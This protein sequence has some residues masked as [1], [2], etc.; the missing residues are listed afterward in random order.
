MDNLYPHYEHALNSSEDVSPIVEI[1]SSIGW[2]DLVYRDTGISYTFNIPQ[3]VGKYQIHKGFDI[4]FQTKPKWIFRK[5]SKV[6]LG[7]EWSDIEVK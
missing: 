4:Y 5:L 2:S 7:W 3:N 1:P 6:L